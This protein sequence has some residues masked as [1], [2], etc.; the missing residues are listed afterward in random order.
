M[1]NSEALKIA[2]DSGFPLQIAVERQVS[3]TSWQH[4]WAVRYVEHAWSN[5]LD[6]KSG[7]IDIVLQ[8]RN[9]STFLVVE[10]KRVREATWLFMHSK[11]ESNSRRHAKSWVS[12]AIAGGQFKHFGWH[13]MAV[14][15]SSPEAIYCAMRG[16]SASDRTSLL[17][18]VGG[19]LVSATEALANE[20]RDL[21]PLSS[22]S[23]R[24][25]FNVIVTTADLKIV[26]F[27][28]RAIS[29]ADGTLPDGQ[30]E[31]VPFVRFRKQLATR[32]EKLTPEDFKNQH[33]VAYAKQNTVFVVRA[34]ALV[35]FLNEFEV[36]SD[37]VRQFG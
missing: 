13:D 8:G 35:Q 9:R 20:E 5:E 15:P 23:I 6:Q 1:T 30:I 12:H 27:D 28:P 4:G 11:G 29:L 26:K 24:F 10:C 19:E 36:P 37:S 18:R 34:E 31:D 7:F 2:N 22:N 25:Y 3:D 17:E 33:D 32:A 21:R 14:D 16:Q